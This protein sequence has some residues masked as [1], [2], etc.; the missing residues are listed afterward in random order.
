MKVLFIG[1]IGVI[2]RDR[3]EGRR[4]FVNALG[5]P[6]EQARGTDFLHSEKLGGSRYFGV[7]PLS[8]AARICFG[9][10]NW[11]TDRP[12][13]QMFIEFEVDRPQSVASAASELESQGYTLLHA[14]RKDPWGQTVARLQTE[15]G[16][17][18]GVS[19]V[20]WMHR[21]AK[22]K[23]RRRRVSRHKRTAREQVSSAR[24]RVS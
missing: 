3:G 16:V 22:P 11:P 9:D 10:E 17:L 15:D 4:F 2:T 24:P 12:V 8:E 23:A 7:W 19:Y 6:L 5:L 18:I 20:P 21:P 14:P 13:P 1:S